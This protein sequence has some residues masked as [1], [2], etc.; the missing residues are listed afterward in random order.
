MPERQFD[1]LVEGEIRLKLRFFNGA[2]D[3]LLETPMA[4]DQ[5]AKQERESLV[6]RGTVVLSRKLRWWLR[7]FG[8]TVEVVSPKRLRDEFTAEAQALAALYRE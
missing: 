6:V 2:G 8:P 5:Q 3:H 7:S 1:F 4:A